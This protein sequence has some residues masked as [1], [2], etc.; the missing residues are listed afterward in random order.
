MN[1]DP[2]WNLERA[3]IEISARHSP[4]SLR[5]GHVRNLMLEVWGELVGR[6]RA[7]AEVE[8]LKAKYGTRTRLCRELSITSGT[9]ASLEAYYDNLPP[10]QHRGRL[11]PGDQIGPWTLLRRLGR[12]GSS[13]V[14]RASAK[15]YGEAAL[16]IPDSGNAKGQRFAAELELM[17]RIHGAK[18]VMPLIATSLDEK[19]GDKGS[20]WLAMP[21]AREIGYETVDRDDPFFVIRGAASMATTLSRLHDQGISHR[22]IKPANIYFLKKDW[23]LADFGIASFPGKKAMTENGRKLG[24]VHFIAPEMLNSPST[25]DG[26]RADTYSLAKTIWV[27]LSGQTFPPPGEQRISVEGLRISSYVTIPNV[28]LLDV[29][30]DECTRHNPLERPSAHDIA[31]RLT[32]LQ[33]ISKKRSK[34]MVS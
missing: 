14:W 11:K 12:G 15:V 16:K 33:G 13:E 23:V 25:A 22:D 32:S 10:E 5:H 4:G 27:L 31:A 18:G 7:L 29:L 8:V 3:F 2:D 1:V 17:R 20:P 19:S 21:I 24:P 28:Q 26:R 34:S 6:T 9:L 30:I